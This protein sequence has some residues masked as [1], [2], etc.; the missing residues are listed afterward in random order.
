MEDL[1]FPKKIKEEKLR[2]ICQNFD[3]FG[4]M[5]FLMPYMKHISGNLKIKL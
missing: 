1:G 3:F 4:G 2:S 5:D